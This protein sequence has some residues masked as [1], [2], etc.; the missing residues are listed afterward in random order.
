MLSSLHH[1][2]IGFCHLP[3]S[4]LVTEPIIVCLTE[5]HHPP[6]PTLWVYL[7]QAPVPFSGV[8]PVQFRSGP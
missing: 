1:V 6:C 8:G 4:F 2:E 3:V 5:Q 7:P